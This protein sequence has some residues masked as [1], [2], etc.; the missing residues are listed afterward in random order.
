VDRLPLAD[1]TP[2]DQKKG[3]GARILHRLA[4]TARMYGFDEITATGEKSRDPKTGELRSVGHY[5]FAR[6]G[7][8]ADI[9]AQT[10]PRP[11]DLAECTRISELLITEEG[12]K[13]W[14][15]AGV[16]VPHMTFDLTQG[17]KSWE[18]LSARLG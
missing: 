5:A 6:L 1:K 12:R 10:P 7:F 15:E 3:I 11:F 8:D 13:F 16:I 14:L 2:K 4:N 9:P 17:S 18:T